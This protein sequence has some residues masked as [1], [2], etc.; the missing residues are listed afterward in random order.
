MNVIDPAAQL[1]QG[2]PIAAVTNLLGYTANNADPQAL[3]ALAREVVNG[4]GSLPTGYVRLGTASAM[5]QLA[6]TCIN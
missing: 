4:S 3:R 1:N 6:G 5:D 2:Y